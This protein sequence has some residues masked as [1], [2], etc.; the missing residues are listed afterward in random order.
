MILKKAYIR[1]LV[2]SSLI[3]LIFKFC[4]FKSD[5]KILVKSMDGIG[6]ILVRSRLAEKIVEKYGAENVYFLMKEHYKSLGEMLGYNVIE[7]PRKSEKNFFRRLKMMYQ[8][9]KIYSPK[10]FFNIEFGNDSIVANIYAKEKIGRKDDYPT[11]QRYNK[12][13]TKT[14]E[15]SKNNKKVLENIKDIAE[16]I[17]NEKIK[18]EDIIPN[19][20]EKFNK[21]EEGIVIAVGSTARDRVCSPNRMKEYILEVSKFYPNEKIILVGNGELQKQYANFLLEELP[22]LNIKNL[23]DKTTLKEVF[24]IVASSKLFVGFESGLYNFCFVIRKKGIALFKNVDVPFAHE[25]PWLKIIGPDEEK[26]D[27]LFDENYPDEKINNISVKKFRKAVEE[28]R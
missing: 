4:N 18:L 22:G 9:N 1:D 5:G 7:I 12:Y 16:N 21:K 25:V 8:I 6:D 3:N 14:F 28:L 11:V 23:I 19:L 13:Y 17:L 10:K 27:N 26:I 15:F 20:G 2:N 24:E